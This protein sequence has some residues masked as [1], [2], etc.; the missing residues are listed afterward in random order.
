MSLTANKFLIAAGSS[1]RK[2]FKTEEV[3]TSEKI[4]SLEEKPKRVLIIGGGVIGCEYASFFSAIGSDVTVV[5][6]MDSILPGEDPEVIS[7]LSRE[8]KKKKIRVFTGAKAEIFPGKE[9]LVRSASG[10]IREPF[11]AVF[12]ATGRKPNLNSLDLASARVELTEKGFI[13]TNLFMQTSESHIYAA[14]DCIETPMLAYTASKEA[15]TAAAHMAGKIPEPADYAS[16]PRLTFSM[17]QA[18][19]VGLSEKDAAG[20]GIPVSIYIYFFKA[21]GKAVVEGKDAGFVKIIADSSNSRIIGASAVGDEIADTINELAVIIRN[22]LT[23]DEVLESVH[24]HPSY[25]EI[26]TEALLFGK[27]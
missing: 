1:P 27:A 2:I 17:P 8:F 16:M 19:S 6:M 12:E 25:S 24:I 4:F 26:I 13:R 21:I 3:F 14:G 11:D 10:E 22:R 20:A 9:A 7:A 15:E 5:E 18:G 23:V